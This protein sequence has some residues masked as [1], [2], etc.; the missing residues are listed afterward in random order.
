MDPISD[1]HYGCL[2]VGDHF[3]HLGVRKPALKC[4]PK[5]T[6]LTHTVRAGSLAKELGI[7]QF[8]DLDDISW[9]ERSR[10][11]LVEI[12]HADCGSSGG[13]KVFCHRQRRSSH[14]NATTN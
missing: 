12:H 11:V 7:T 9:L 10:Y 6:L 3:L 5:I 4:D 14:P 1:L 13:R 8:I 2:A